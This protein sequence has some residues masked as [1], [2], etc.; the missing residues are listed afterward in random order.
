[1]DSIPS[2]NS[3][4]ESKFPTEEDD[5]SCNSPYVDGEGKLQPCLGVGV[6]TIIE[7]CLNAEIK[8]DPRYE[9]CEYPSYECNGAVVDQ[10][11]KEGSTVYLDDVSIED[12]SIDCSFCNSEVAD[13]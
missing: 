1:M 6:H 2:H 10:W 12:E 11:W 8:V 3:C 5:H 9:N 4:K 13:N 7:A